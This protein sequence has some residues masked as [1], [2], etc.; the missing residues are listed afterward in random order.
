MRGRGRPVLGPAHRAQPQHTSRG[1]ARRPPAR[2]AHPGVRPRRPP[3]HGVFLRR[4]AHPRTLRPVPRPPGHGSAHAGRPV[5][6]R[7]QGLSHRLHPPGGVGHSHRALVPGREHDHPTACRPSVLGP[8][9]DHPSAQDQ[10]A[11]VGRAPRER[12]EQAGDPRAVPQRDVLRPQHLWGRGCLAV[13]LPPA[14]SGRES[15]GSRGAGHP[16]GQSR[17]I[18]ALQQ[19]ERGEKNAA[20]DPEPDGVAGP[21]VRRGGGAV[22]CGLL[23]S[24]RPYPQPHRLRLVRPAGSGSVFQRVRPAAARIPTLRFP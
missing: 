10:R 5:L 13:L 2:S 1:A 7:A 19:P 24:P 21:C 15:G 18:L 12:P 4:K 14:G 3:D 22:V 8:D 20:G 6:L 17:S 23:G 16:A 11:V 9:G